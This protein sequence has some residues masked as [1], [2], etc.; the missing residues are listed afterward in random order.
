MEDIDPLNSTLHHPPNRSRNCL[1]NRLLHS[2]EYSLL[3][4]FA[5]SA[6]RYYRKHDDHTKVFK[7]ETGIA[8][9]LSKE[10]NY[11]NTEVLHEVLDSYSA[12]VSGF[13]KEIK[14]VNGFQEHYTRYAIWIDAISNEEPYY[15]AAKRWYEGFIKD[16][17]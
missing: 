9:L 6:P 1:R 5:A 2:K 15:V 3:P 12:I 17:K 8:T 13:I 11:G 10:R 4:H 14:A 7:V 16:K